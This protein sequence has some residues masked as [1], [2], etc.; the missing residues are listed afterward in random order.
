MTGSPSRPISSG[1]SA[2][3]AGET[4][5]LLPERAALWSRRRTLLIADWHLGKAGVFG[6][7]GL[8]IPD[9]GMDDELARLDRVLSAHDVARILV[10]GDLMHAPPVAADDWPDKLHAWLQRHP[11]V[12]LSVV[13]GN[14]DRVTVA[15]L[16]ETFANR[17]DWHAQAVDE[18]PF[19]FDHEPYEQQ[20]RYVIAG[21]LHP[22][23]RLRLAGD[24]LRAPV[25]WLRENY[26][27]LPAFGGFTGG[28]NIRP[29]GQ[30][31]VYAVGMDAVVDIT[32]Q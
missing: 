2:D 3:C 16:P 29:G 24:S 28:A 19:R 32:R 21:H 26:A 4:L 23:R 12:G 22:T 17:I 5:L 18:G 7:R 30:D 20:G 1:V 9:G 15:Q 14:H 25:F 8:A 6:R 27:V 13:A 31:R 11:D 10:L